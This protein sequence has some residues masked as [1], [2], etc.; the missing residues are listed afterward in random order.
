MTNVI[1]HI[2][3][4]FNREEGQGLVEYAGIAGLVALAIAGATVLGLLDAP[5]ASLFNG[6]GDCV[7]FDSTTPCGP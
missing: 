5:L 6:I 4:W 1:M 3:A 2:M 7:D